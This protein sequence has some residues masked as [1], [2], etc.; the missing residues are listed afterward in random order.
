MQRMIYVGESIYGRDK[1]INKSITGMTVLHS[2]I[3]ISFS[4]VSLVVAVSKRANFAHFILL[5]H[6]KKGR[7]C[8]F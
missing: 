7:N 8:L 4:N 5:D 1:I 3:S 2:E 6:I